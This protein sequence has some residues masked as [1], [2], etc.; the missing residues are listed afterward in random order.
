MNG[1][2][3]GLIIALVVVLLVGVLLW[4]LIEQRG[5]G[6]AKFTVSNLLTAEITIGS[7]DTHAATDAIDTAAKARGI[8]TPDQVAPQTP[9]TVRLRRL[10]WVDDHP[11]NNVYESI[12][13]QHLGFLITSTTTTESA[14]AYLGAF[15]FQ[16]VVTDQ[17]RGD[18]TDAGR[19]LLGAVRAQHPKV[20]V[21]FYMMDAGH[22][23]AELIAD[24]AFAVEDR[25][26]RLVATLLDAESR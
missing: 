11:D 12:A 2:V 21:V 5:S 18:D 4:R 8:E 13:L 17:T 22:R 24:G 15:E 16:V 26:D 23:R 7:S 25:P 14:L 20:P 19:K 10:L 1:T 6:S 9:A 3:A